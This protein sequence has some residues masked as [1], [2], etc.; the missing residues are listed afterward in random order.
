VAGFSVSTT[1]RALGG[2]GRIAPATREAVRAAAAQL[3]Y[4]RNSLARSMI[5]GRTET[6]GVVCA[7]MGSPFFAE[8]LRGISD[9]AKSLGFSMLIVNT[10]EDLDAEID[11]IALLREKQVDG[12]IVAPAD[13]QRMEHLA[14]FQQ[15]GRPLVLFD[16]SS[17]AIEADSVTVDDVAATEQAVEYL[18]DRG[19]TR[20][21]IVT[22]LRVD[23]EADWASLLYPIDE[24]DRRTLNPSSR[25]LLGY[26]RAHASR[27]VAVEPQLVAR[28]GATS[29]QSAR[30]ATLRLLG[31]DD[32]PTAIVTVDNSTSVGAYGAVRALGVRVPDDISFVAFD[33]LDWT[34][35]V[36]P[37]LT[38]VEQPVH[39]LGVKAADLLVGRISGVDTTP[40]ADHM[41]QTRLIERDS[42]RTTG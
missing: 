36:T 14:A 37:A 6:I 18:I 40:M 30:E 22:E 16:R 12:L 5:T 27:G 11:A 34:T 41:L 13:V 17:S 28:T 15:E 2:Y 20:I 39:E 24:V 19:H 32:P 42:T 31:A 21:G 38:V 4:R 23:R 9:R 29:V 25:R 10:D 26:L 33:N 35:L 3:G 7:D 1:A 8:A